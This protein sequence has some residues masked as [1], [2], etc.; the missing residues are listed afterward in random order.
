[1]PFY[2]PTKKKIDFSLLLIEL[3]DGEIEVCTAVLPVGDHTEDFMKD[4]T[5]KIYEGSAEF[6]DGN[7]AIDYVLYVDKVKASLLALVSGAQGSEPKMSARSS[8]QEET[9]TRSSKISESQSS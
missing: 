1:M 2:N 7:F 4:S 3:A 9:A 6:D 8:R 5:Q